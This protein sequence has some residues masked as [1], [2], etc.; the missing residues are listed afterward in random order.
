MPDALE[1]DCSNCSEQQKMISDKLVQH[2]IDHRP[3]DWKLLE[4]Q[5]DSSGTYREKYLESKIDVEDE[6]DHDETD[7]E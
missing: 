1:N 3:D 4:E 5:Y 2:L 7:E 6:S